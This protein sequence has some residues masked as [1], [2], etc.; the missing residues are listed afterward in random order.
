MRVDAFRSENMTAAC[1]GNDWLKSLIP[2]IRMAVVNRELPPLFTRN[3]VLAIGIKDPNYNLYNY[4]AKNK[5]SKNRKSLMSRNIGGST[6]YWFNEK[7][8]DS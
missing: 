2:Q 7:L 4:D 1:S 8:F 3:E 5:A 6:Y